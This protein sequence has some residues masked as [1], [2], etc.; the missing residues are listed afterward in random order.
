MRGLPGIFQKHRYQTRV[1]RSKVKRDAEFA[2]SLIGRLIVPT[3]AEWLQEM[4]RADDWLTNSIPA[5]QRLIC[6]DN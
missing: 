4:K 3:Y 5:P 2:R 6:G 1:D